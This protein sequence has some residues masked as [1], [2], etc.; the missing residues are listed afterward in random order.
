[1]DCEIVHGEDIIPDLAYKII[2]IG[3]A[4]V[5]KSCL[6]I[7]A[8]KNEYKEDY[9]VTIGADSSSLLVKIDNKITELQIWDTAGSEKFRSMI[10]VFFNNCNG[11][12]LV[13]DITRKSSFEA[14]DFWLKMLRDNTGP[15]T[16]IILVGNKI[17]QEDKREISTEMGKL[18]AEKNDLFEFVETSAKTGD[19]VIQVFK[20]IAKSLY[21]DTKH[22]EKSPKRNLKL[23]QKHKKND[24]NFC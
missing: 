17:D 9:E 10:R 15:E 1:M 24:I 11:A 16:K 20:K 23:K 4:S 3:E 2:V 8:V 19:G 7:R 14:L 22:A 18:F 13:Y 21:I 5:G 12:F 6:M